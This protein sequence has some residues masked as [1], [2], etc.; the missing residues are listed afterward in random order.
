MLKKKKSHEDKHTCT[1]L[2]NPWAPWVKKE[3]F[4]MEIIEYLEPNSNETTSHQILQ[5][6]GKVML[7][8]IFIYL[9][10]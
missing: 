9:N 1:L 7:R 10:T 2:N 6:I 5:D 3:K 4:Q 8:E